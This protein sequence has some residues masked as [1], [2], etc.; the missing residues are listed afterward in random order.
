M[1]KAQKELIAEQKKTELDVLRGLLPASSYVNIVYVGG[2]PAVSRFK[3]LVTEEID[4]TTKRYADI[5]DITWL[6]ARAIGSSYKEGSI[7]IGGYGLNRAYTIVYGLGRALY[8]NG[9]PCTG[10]DCAS[11]DHNNGDQDYT[12]GKIHS[13]GGYAFRMRLI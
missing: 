3:V 13:D 2:T 10:E 5:R 7:R 4:D 8:P 11:N 6:V 1:T 12:V 9:S